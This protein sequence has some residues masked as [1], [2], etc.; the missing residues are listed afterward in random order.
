M[1]HHHHHCHSHDDQESC[2]HEESHHDC[3]GSYDH[4]EDHQSFAHDLL[5]IADEAWMEVLKDKIKEQIV[6]IDGAHLDELAKI[7]A[8][9]N[10]A[11]WSHKL[12]ENHVNEE[13]HE[14]VADFFNK[15]K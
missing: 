11:R 14:K 1:S 4:H 15:K 12:G 2:C 5:E 6:K 7:V 8:E 10:S 3:C 9:A 13:Y